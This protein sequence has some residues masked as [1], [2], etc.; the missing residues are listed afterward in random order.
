MTALQATSSNLYNMVQSPPTSQTSVG[1]SA[2]DNAAIN[3]SQDQDTASLQ[4]KTKESNSTLQSLLAE[5]TKIYSNLEDKNNTLSVEQ[6]HMEEL[7]YTFKSKS[8]E[9]SDKA[10]KTGEDA[11]ASLDE[12]LEKRSSDKLEHN[13]AYKQSMALYQSVKYDDISRRMTESEDLINEPV[14]V[15]SQRSVMRLETTMQTYAQRTTDTAQ[16]MY[17]TEI[18]LEELQKKADEDENE[19]FFKFVCDQLIN[20]LDIY[21]HDYSLSDAD[22]NLD[23][24]TVLNEKDSS[25]PQNAVENAVEIIQNLMESGVSENK[26]GMNAVEDAAEDAVVSLMSNQYVL[27]ASDK[28]NG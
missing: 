5:H 22:L 10:S 21:I 1:Q 18:S 23:N 20:E 13:P 2:F 26:D 27:N 3:G 9:V 11:A 14:Q 6:S 4:Q 24:F 25:S 7:K 8:D 15:K 28:Y 12:S 16:A 19:E 17:Q